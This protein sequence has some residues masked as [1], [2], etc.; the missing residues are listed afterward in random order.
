MENAGIIREY[1]FDPKRRIISIKIR[2]SDEEK[3]DGFVK[4]LLDNDSDSSR[5]DWYFNPKDDKYYFTVKTLNAA[6]PYKN[7]NKQ[8]KSSLKE[9]DPES[10]FITELRGFFAG[11]TKED[12]DLMR[13]ILEV[14]DVEPKDLDALIEEQYDEYLKTL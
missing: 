6:L 2:S 14:E 8:N 10:K 7:K 4:K 3:L 9:V 13:E 5:F 1:K 11:N 12:V